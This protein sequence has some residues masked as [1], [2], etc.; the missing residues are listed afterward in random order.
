VSKTELNNPIPVAYTT[1]R[2]FT[3]GAVAREALRMRRR[4]DLKDS[5]HTFAEFHEAFGVNSRSY[6]GWKAELE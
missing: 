3:S 1:V 5:G 6:Y 4:A 2:L